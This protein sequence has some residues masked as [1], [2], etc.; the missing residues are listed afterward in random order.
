MRLSFLSACIAA[1]A[2][3]AIVSVAHAMHR[4]AAPTRVRAIRSAVDHYRTVAWLFE[5]AAKTH[6]TPTSYSYRR[7]TDPAY[8]QWTLKEWQKQEYDARLHALGA[9]QRRLDVKLPAS[10]GI[11]AALDRRI[12]YAR[13]LAVKLQKVSTGQAGATR[14]LA[15]AKRMPATEKLYTWQVKAATMTLKLSRRP[16]SHLSLIGPRWLTDAF[17]CIHHYEGAW[18][19]NSGNGYYGGLQMDAGFMRTYGDE[20]VRRWG[21]ADRWPAWAQ[22]G[23]AVRAYRSGRGFWPWPNTARACGLL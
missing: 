11:H 20:Y 22:I 14:A 16:V 3:A 18:N 5:R 10:P 1:V 4:T 13:T 12:A 2:A 6:P 15:S 19:A 7:S 17:T 9:L 23:A 8:L 21:T